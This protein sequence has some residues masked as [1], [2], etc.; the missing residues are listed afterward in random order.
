MIE[1]K[2]CGQVIN[3][4]SETDFNNFLYELRDRPFKDANRP[5]KMD[6]IKMM[7]YIGDNCLVAEF[8]RISNKLYQRFGLV[9]A[10]LAMYATII[11]NFD[12]IPNQEG[13]A[14]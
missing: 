3:R 9:G 7:Q 2:D 8:L 12:L 6:A 5:P 10:P 11:C 13:A 4:I 14:K 1:I